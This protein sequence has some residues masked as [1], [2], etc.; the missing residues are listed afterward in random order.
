MDS[1]FYSTLQNINYYNFST[2]NISIKNDYFEE[3]KKKN[4]EFSNLLAD[5]KIIFFDEKNPNVYK[6]K[7]LYKKGSFVDLVKL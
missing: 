3:I 4:T 6:N 1:R 7:I 5:N 2:K